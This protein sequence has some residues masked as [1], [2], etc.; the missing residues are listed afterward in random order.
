LREI[1]I[2]RWRRRGTFPGS[3]ALDVLRSYR[4]NAFGEPI[5]L[6][7]PHA[8]Y[9]GLGLYLGD[10]DETRRSVYRELLRGAPDDKSLGD[11]RPALNQD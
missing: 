9:L 6:L 10:D 3:A 2:T 4:A 1:S 8:R 11:L 7:T 5:A